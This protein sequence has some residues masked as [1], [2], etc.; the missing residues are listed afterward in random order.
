MVEHERVFVVPAWGRWAMTLD[1]FRPGFRGVTD[2]VVRIRCAGQC[3]AESALWH[4][5]IGRGAV[6]TVT[7]VSFACEGV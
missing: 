1:D 5:P 6:P 2:A 3:W 4:E 7:R